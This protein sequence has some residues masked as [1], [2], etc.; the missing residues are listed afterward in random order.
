MQ[1]DKIKKNQLKKGQKNQQTKESLANPTN[2]I[3]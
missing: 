3:I 1:N 2:W